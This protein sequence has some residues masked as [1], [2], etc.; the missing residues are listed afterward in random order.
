MRSRFLGSIVAVPLIVLCSSAEP[1]RTLQTQ[2]FRSPDRKTVA[3]IRFTKAPE[4]TAE[5]RLELRSEA[6]RLLA[7]RSYSSSDGEHGFGITKAAWTPD[8]QFFVYS[9][10]SSGGHQAWHTPVQFYS[11]RK[12][13]IIKL[14]DLLKDAVSNPQ[15]VVSGADRVTVD[16]W[17]SKQT[18]TVSLGQ[19]SQQ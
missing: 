13:R 15:F 6:G 19:I 9:L 14:D 1:S 7:R 2:E 11:R 3:I 12:N 4:A 10:E 17:F 8:S 16:L 5:S 18:K